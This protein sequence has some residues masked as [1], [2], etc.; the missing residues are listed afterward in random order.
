MPFDG[1]EL[2]SRLRRITARF[3][4]KPDGVPNLRKVSVEG[5]IYLLRHRELWPDDFVWNYTKHDCCAMGLAS[6]FWNRNLA[7]THFLAKAIRW[8]RDDVRHVCLWLGRGWNGQ[9]DQPCFETITPEEV[10]SA[11]ERVL[12][13]RA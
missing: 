7:N 2:P 13:L 4:P 9:I 11:F 1:T 8:Q 12:R 3:Q 5:M 10:A 6:R